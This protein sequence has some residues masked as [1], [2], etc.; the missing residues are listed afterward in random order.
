[1]NINLSNT[2]KQAFID[3]FFKGVCAPVTLYEPFKMPTLQ[4]VN[5]IKS[6]YSNNLCEGLAKDWQKI[7]NDFKRVLGN[8]EPTAK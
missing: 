8:Y 5:E 7:G 3:G 6:P 1:M 4:Q 2:P